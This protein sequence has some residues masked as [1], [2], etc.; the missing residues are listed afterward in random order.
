MPS[1][2]AG[3]RVALSVGD[4]DGGSDSVPTTLAEL[5]AAVGSTDATPGG[6]GVP[7]AFVG[8]VSVAV[9]IIDG[10]G[11]LGRAGGDGTTVALAFDAAWRLF[12]NSSVG[13]GVGSTP[14][15]ADGVGAL[16]GTADGGMLGR[17][18][19]AA[20]A[21]SFALGL[22]GAALSGGVGEA[23]SGAPLDGAIDAGA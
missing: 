3:L 11:V 8:F 12:C 9:G 13:K 4:A 20:L 5:E 17:L 22:D 2:P 10:G 23:D 16:E 18:C 21:P 19:G 14:D 15:G 1:V 6:A 7:P